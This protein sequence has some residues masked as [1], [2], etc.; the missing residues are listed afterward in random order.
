MATKNMAV[1]G[2]LYHKSI[3]LRISRVTNLLIWKQVFTNNAASRPP[4][5]QETPE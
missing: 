2:I 1:I 5:M 4:I 3:S